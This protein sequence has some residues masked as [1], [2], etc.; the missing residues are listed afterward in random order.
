MKTTYLALL[1]GLFLGTILAFGSFADFVLAA[2]CGA[3]ELGVG[4]YLEGRVD[5]HSILDRRKK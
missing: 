2:L 5:V 3:A 4:P 1:V